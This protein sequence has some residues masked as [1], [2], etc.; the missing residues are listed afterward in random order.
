M[1]RSIL[2]APSA[3]DGAQ[4]DGS[5]CALKL[6]KLAAGDFDAEHALGSTHYDEQPSW[7]I[8]GS[9]PT[10]SENNK[11]ANGVLPATTDRSVR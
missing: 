6:V 3:R 9:S 5:C 2:M 11:S 7:R 8:A 10:A 4:W 1:L